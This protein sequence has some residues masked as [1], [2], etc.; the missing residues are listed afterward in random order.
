[1][2]VNYC[3]LLSL[4]EKVFTNDFNKLE[5]LIWCNLP[6]AITILYWYIISVK[7]NYRSMEELER[8]VAGT[9]SVITMC[10]VQGARLLN[11]SIFT[12]TASSKSRCISVCSMR[13]DCK[14]IN[15]NVVDR[16]CDINTQV[17]TSYKAVHDFDSQRSADYIYASTIKCWLYPCDAR[18]SISAFTLILTLTKILEYW[19]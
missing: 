3:W 11:H 17:A 19:R 6:A 2:V 4:D 9:E 16:T 5:Y 1:M 14:S 18:G 7:E 15:F 10:L 8:Y 12:F 13:S